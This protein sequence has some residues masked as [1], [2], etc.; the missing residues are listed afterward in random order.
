MVRMGDSRFRAL[1]AVTVMMVEQL[2]LEIM[3]LCHAASSGLT[4]GTISGT[5]GSR[6]KAEELS[7]KTA[8]ALTMAGANRFA[9]SFSAAP[10]TMSTPSNAPSQA[11]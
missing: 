11:S 8:P 10:R 7:T 9:M 5:L 4:S 2:G 1:T 3:P 6:R